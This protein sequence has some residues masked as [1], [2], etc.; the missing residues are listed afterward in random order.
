MT[1]A[2]KVGVRVVVKP[3]GHKGKY[4]LAD[5]DGLVIELDDPVGEH[6]YDG[7]TKKNKACICKLEDIELEETEK[8]F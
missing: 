2:P 1:K 6:S 8:K 3:T 5:T 7:V 4:I